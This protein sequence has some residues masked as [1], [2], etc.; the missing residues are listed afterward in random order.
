MDYNS[1]IDNLLASLKENGNYRYFLNIE[2]DSGK[3]PHFNFENHLG[4]RKEAIN[5]CSNDYL[6]MSINPQVIDKYI[7]VARVAGVGSGGTRNIS[8]TTIYH[9]QLEE[10]LAE[11]HEKEAA[12][13]FGGAYLANLTALYTLGKIYP[14]AI[15]ISDQYNHA[16]LIEGI[17]ASGCDKHIFKHNDVDELKNILKNLPA[18]AL[19]IIVFESVYSISGTISPIREIVALANEYNCMTY[20]DEVHAVGLYGDKGAGMASKENIAGEIDMI[21]GTLAKGFGVYGGYIVGKRNM[22][23]AIRSLGSGF[24]FTTSLPPALC[25]AASESI[26]IASQ[27][28][29]LRISLHRKVKELRDLFKSNH[30]NYID[31]CSHITPIP[32]GNSSRCKN[33]SD[34]LL[35]NHGVYLQPI[36]YPTVP[37]GK[38]CLRIVTTPK[39]NYSDMVHLAKSLYQEVHTNQQ[40]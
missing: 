24:I 5:W 40:E 20:L 12:L 33:I 21:N 28:N 7:S 37:R 4:E 32:I 14:D 31:N 17:K 16:S 26:R 10:D 19:K 34:N 11:L 18:T 15:F 38:E 27:S 3:L 35:N 36:N 2:K 9:K 30:I 29:E 8:G 23:D 22:V 1:P 6:G 25:A 13:I 39:H